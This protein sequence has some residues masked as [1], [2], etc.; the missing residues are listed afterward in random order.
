M[1]HLMKLFHRDNHRDFT[2]NYQFVIRDEI[3]EETTDIT[4]IFIPTKVVQQRK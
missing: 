3:Q 1:T 4:T 2:E